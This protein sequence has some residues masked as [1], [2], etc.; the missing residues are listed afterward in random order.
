[1]LP[2]HMDFLHKLSRGSIT[3]KIGHVPRYVESLYKWGFVKI[4]PSLD[5]WIDKPWR[6]HVSLTAV[7]RFIVGTTNE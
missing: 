4:V 7:G 2:I 1:V 5:W 6:H 3:Y